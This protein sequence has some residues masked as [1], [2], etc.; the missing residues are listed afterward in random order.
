MSQLDGKVAL[1]TGGGRGI[2]AAIAKRFID[3]GAKI[4][5]S[6]IQKD[7]LQETANSRKSNKVAACAGDVT[8]WDDVQKMVA[9]TVKFGGKIDVLVNNAGIDPGG[10]ITDIDIALWKKILDVN[11][12]GPFLCMRAALPQMVKQVPGPLLG[13]SLIGAD[14]LP[15]QVGLGVV[16]YRLPTD[17][18]VLSYF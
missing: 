12:N 14:Q 8:N 15:G 13:F 4:V 5:I 6:D 10:S 18:K 3:D 11:L 9:E 16:P 7:L 2:G 1:I 17:I